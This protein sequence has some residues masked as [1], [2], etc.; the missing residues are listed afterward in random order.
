MLFLLFGGGTRL[1]DRGRGSQ[2]TCP[3]C[4]NT[5]SWQR[6]CRFHEVTFFLIPVLRWGREEVECC[7]VCGDLREL[8]ASEPPAF[9]Q[10]DRG[11]T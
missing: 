9:R 7:P 4:H 3:R 8:P 2:R 1:K 5:A 6:L 10:A 11:A